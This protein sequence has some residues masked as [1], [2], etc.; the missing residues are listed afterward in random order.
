MNGI[1]KSLLEKI[2]N[3]IETDTCN[4]YEKLKIYDP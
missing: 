4:A 1:G 2:N 3:I